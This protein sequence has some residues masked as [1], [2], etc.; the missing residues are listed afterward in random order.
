MKPRAGY[1]L[2]GLLEKTGFTNIVTK[3][4]QFNM[5]HTDKC[6]ELFWYTLS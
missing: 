3:E 1:E 6:G 5:N 2:G 4:A